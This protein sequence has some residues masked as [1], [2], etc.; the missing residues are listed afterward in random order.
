MAASDV[1]NMKYLQPK[2]KKSMSDL[3]ATNCINQLMNQKYFYGR[4]LDFGPLSQF[5][6]D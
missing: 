1:Y 3:A 4:M 5:Y 6:F 2:I